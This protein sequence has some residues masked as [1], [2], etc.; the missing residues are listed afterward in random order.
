LLASAAAVR[1]SVQQQAF[2]AAAAHQRTAELAKQQH[3]AQLAQVHISFLFI[4]VYEPLHSNATDRSSRQL[5]MPA[6]RAR[7]ATE[8]VF[9]FIY[10]VNF[11]RQDALVAQMQSELAHLQALMAETSEQDQVGFQVRRANC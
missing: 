11:C 7:L 4:L 9:L 5:M 10:L 1:E 3:E 8:L 6:L 2:V